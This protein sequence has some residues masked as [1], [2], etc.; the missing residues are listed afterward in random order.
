MEMGPAATLFGPE[1]MAWGQPWGPGCEGALVSQAEPQGW[2]CPQGPS[3]AL[4]LLGLLPSTVRNRLGQTSPAG[5]GKPMA[6]VP[7]LLA[8]A[9]TAMHSSHELPKPPALGLPAAMPDIDLISHRGF[10][11]PGL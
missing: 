10:C 6:A 2:R 7:S 1:L 8:Q 3:R 11:M 5:P 9:V 4:D